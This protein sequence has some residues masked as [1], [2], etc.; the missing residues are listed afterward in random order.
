MTGAEMEDWNPNDPALKEL[1]APHETAGVL[2]WHRARVPSKKIM[3]ML[4][5]RA[6]QLVGALQKASEQETL[7]AKLGREIY[8]SG[9]PEQETT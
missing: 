8:D 1:K 9:F 5:L 2:R 7:A 3:E 4:G 6:T